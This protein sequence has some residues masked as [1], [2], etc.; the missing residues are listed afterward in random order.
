M[1]YP[2]NILFRPYKIQDILGESLTSQI[3]LVERQDKKLRIKQ[4][5]VIKLFKK[6]TSSEEASLQMESLLR[7]RHSPHLVKV[8]SFER[9]QNRPALIL[10]YI[11]GVNLKELMKKEELTPDEQAYICSHILSGLKELKKSGLVHGDLSPSNIL[12]DIKGGVYLI[13]YG[14]AN[15]SKN[16]YGTSPFVAPEI[17][18]GKK[19][20]FQSDLFSL[21]VLEKVLCRKLSEETLNQLETPHFICKK[22][23]L[24][25]KDPEKR[26]EKNYCFSREACSSLN[27]KVHQ[28]LTLKKFFGRKSSSTLSLQKK[29]RVLN[30]MPAISL[31][32]AFFIL[33][34]IVNPFTSYGNYSLNK[35]T[36][37]GAEISIRSSNWVH[38]QID[39]FKG[40]TPMNIRIWQGGLYKLK[41]KTQEASGV[42][43]LKLKPGKKITL[44]DDDFS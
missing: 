32:G 17:Y 21:G 27:H 26:T 38:I 42:K 3:F 39:H 34:F 43:Y 8:L 16:N 2:A 11:E 37:R 9:F 14:L 4:N 10:E 35:K 12:I 19:A 28:I 36:S 1:P 24:L 20:S 15:Y 23:P 44:T 7:A 25:H 31:Y 18:E 40:Y 13:D 29:S 6:E 22:S 5:L 33:M 41:W 30:P